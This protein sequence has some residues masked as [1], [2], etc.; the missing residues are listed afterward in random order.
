MKKNKQ[1][2]EFVFVARPFNE[3]DFI[4]AMIALN[5]FILIQ[6]IL[7]S[8][9]TFIAFCVRQQQEKRQNRTIMKKIRTTKKSIEPTEW[10]LEVKKYFILFFV[11]LQFCPLPT[12]FNVSINRA[13]KKNELELCTSV[14]SAHCSCE[15]ERERV[16][17]FRRS[18]HF[19]F[20]SLKRSHR[21][22]FFWSFGVLLRFVL[23]V[24][25][26]L[27]KHTTRSRDTSRQEMNERTR[28]HEN[29]LCRTGIRMQQSNAIAL[30]SISN[31]VGC[32]FSMIFMNVFYALKT[33]YICNCELIQLTLAPNRTAQ[34]TTSTMTTI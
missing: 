22:F 2:T 31:G 20:F 13:K 18:R 16:W 33:K 29:R 19:Y 24:N 1:K 21:F 5:S 32:V 3:I 8:F 14:P 7:I 26:Y 4:C 9:F 6:L 23:L 27:P 28:E 11:S 15:C 12:I 30:I 10:N 17:V 25:S 34:T